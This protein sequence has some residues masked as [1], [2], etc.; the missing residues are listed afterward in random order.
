MPTFL[1]FCS[2][3][4][5][6][7][8]GEE[9]NLPTPLSFSVISQSAQPIGQALLVRIDCPTRLLTQK[10]NGGSHFLYFPTFTYILRAKY[11]KLEMNSSIGN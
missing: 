7:E 3:Y 10:D 5:I 1:I 6:V 11:Q 8:S 9:Q 4:I 2:Q